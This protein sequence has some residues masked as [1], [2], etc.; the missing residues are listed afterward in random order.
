MEALMTHQNATQE[1]WQ[2]RI[3]SWQDS[4]LSQAGWCRQNG[5]KSSQLGYWKKKLWAEDNTAS[6][7]NTIS[8]FVP[9]SRAKSQDRVYEESPPLTVSLPNGLSVSGIDQHNLALAGQLIGL[10]R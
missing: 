10:L 8:A 4:G 3:D 1:Q 6:P 5:V 2:Q 9:V 7:S